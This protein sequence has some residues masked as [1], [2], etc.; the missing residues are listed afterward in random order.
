MNALQMPR[1][2]P[3]EQGVSSRVIAEWVAAVNELAYPNSFMLM[4]H[5]HVIAEGWWKPYTPDA[6]HHLYSLSKSFTSCAVGLAASE[7]LLSIDDLVTKF[8][9]DKLPAQMAEGFSRM[10]LRHLLTMTSGHE[11]C[12]LGHMRRDPE[13][14][15]VRGFFASPLKW[16]PG[17]HFAYNSGATYICGAVVQKLTG[18]S[19]TAYLYPRLLQPLG[20]E[21]PYWDTCPKGLEVGGWGFHLTTEEIANF[22]QMLLQRG[23]WQGRQLVPAAYLAEATA[24]QSDNSMNESPDWK[25]GYGFQFWRSQHNCFRGDGAFGQYALVMPDQDMALAFT[26]GMAGMQEVLTKVWEI[27]LP[28]V[29]GTVA[30]PADPEGVRAL[31]EQCAALRIPPAQGEP[32]TVARS[33]TMDANPL[34][35]LR[36]TIHSDAEGCTLRMMYA[37]RVDDVRAAW[38]A[39]GAGGQTLQY[40]D[41]AQKAAASAGWQEDGSLRVVCCL[42]QTPYIVT[43]NLSFTG[44][45]VRL[46]AKSNLL[47]GLLGFNDWP[48][49]GGTSD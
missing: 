33:F 10:T 17:T 32:S 22:A 16:E 5:G 19:L 30:L 1:S 37:D 29:K 15:W 28:K 42:Y 4:R 34:G 6:R 35:L 7:G 18:Q 3:E 45:R 41:A 21:K 12:A 44:A 49:L 8:F 39:F 38:N 36:L 13:G 27:L 46:E 23:M 2:T 31:R 24:A 48:V 20:I 47:F 25:M 14:D 43:L 9:P 40:F 11:G 26:S